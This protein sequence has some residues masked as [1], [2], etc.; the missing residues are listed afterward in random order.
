ME[1]KRAIAIL[2]THNRWR[3]GEDYEPMLN[4]TDIGI[5]IDT[6]VGYLKNNII[7]DDVMSCK[8]LDEDFSSALDG[9]AK[10]TRKTKP[11]KKF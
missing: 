10:K 2:E 6:V 8:N 5:S 1:L 9:F 4:P 11:N 7:P 3:R